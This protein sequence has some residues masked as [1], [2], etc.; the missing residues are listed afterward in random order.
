MCVNT[1]SSPPR[2]SNTNVNLARFAGL[3]SNC[4]VG[5]IGISA[6]FN[7]SSSS[8][9]SAILSNALNATSSSTFAKRIQSFNSKKVVFKSLAFSFGAGNC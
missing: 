4:C 7:K 3:G 8:I 2:T 5:S 9:A 6:I 1:P